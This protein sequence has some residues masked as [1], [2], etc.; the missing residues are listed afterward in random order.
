[1]SLPE[2]T[3]SASDSS[4][5]DLR[6]GRSGLAWRIAALISAA[7]LIGAL[8]ALRHYGV[9]IDAPALF[10]A[11]DRD[12]F[13]W[14][15]PK[16]RDA[17]DLSAPDP[18]GFKSLYTR[19]PAWDD[20]MHYPAFPGIIAAVANDVFHEHLGWLDD[21]DAH[22]LGL[23]FLHTAGLFLFTL[24]A[25]LLLG[26]W[27]G[28]CA[29]VFLALFPTAVGHAFNNPKDWPCAL[30]YGAGMLAFG[31]AM[32][33]ASARQTWIAAV[34]FGVSMSAKANTAFA[35]VSIVAFAPLGWLVLYHRHRRMPLRFVAAFLTAPFVTFGVF[36][37]LW[38]WMHQGPA[39]TWVH[40][41]HD[42]VKFIAGFGHGARATWTLYPFKAVGVQTPPLVLGCAVLYAL[43]GWITRSRLG[44]S[45]Y[46]LHLC[47]MGVILGRIAMPHS[48][49]YD[50]TRHFLEYVPAMCS[51][52][53]AGAASM[54]RMLQRLWGRRIPRAAVVGLAAAGVASLMLPI[55]RYHP[56]EVSYF[57]FLSGGLGRAQKNHIFSVPPPQDGRVVDTEGDY[58][59]SSVRMADRDLSYIM[60]PG[61]TVAWCGIYPWQLTLD[62]PLRAPQ[63][64]WA[65]IK[66]ADYLIVVNR[67]CEALDADLKGPNPSRPLVID[68]RRGGGLIYRI[69]GP[70]Y[71][72]SS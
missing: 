58:W 61:Q 39:S 38:P 5:F 56:Y 37:W 27:A 59:Y 2:H 42:Y 34:L 15:H 72:W 30:Y 46:C 41:L 54:L 66:D 36:F 24:Y 47:W 57:N 10:Y 21:L 12:L 4:E 28:G 63:P 52:A 62:W 9:A 71:H 68:E 35:L 60:R 70:K 26:P 3:Y 1:M 19:A 20:P 48:N 17:F 25:C 43:T 23:V 33:T 65:P 40:H 45:V 14:T 32:V 11:G 31:W 16:Q 13:G 6:P 67:G 55:V 18:E 50:A 69:Y 22:H 64:R 49:F 29:G 8:G 51:M 7:W 44:F 53:G